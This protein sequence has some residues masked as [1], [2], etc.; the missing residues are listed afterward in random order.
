MKIKIKKEIKRMKY[1]L[2][3]LFLVVVSSKKIGG[4][5][6]NPDKGIVQ[7]EGISSD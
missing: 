7:L 4:K 6:T 2:I 5:F 1:L 3:I